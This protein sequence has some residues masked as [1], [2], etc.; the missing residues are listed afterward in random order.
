[1]LVNWF[2]S[3]F[4]NEHYLKLLLQ[5]NDWKV[6]I[7]QF[8]THLLAAGVLRQLSDKDAPIEYLFRVCGS[9][10]VFHSN[11]YL[12]WVSISFLFQPDLM[13]YWAHTE[14]VNAAPPTPGRLSTISWPPAF[15][16]SE[17]TDKQNGRP[18]SGK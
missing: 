5:L 6:I 14:T 2:L 16:A 12:F 8:C 1:M 7:V 17:D 13:Y 4:P 11:F 15:S 18:L 3:A 9:F 10:F